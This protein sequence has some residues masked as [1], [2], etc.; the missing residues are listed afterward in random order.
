MD[1]SLKETLGESANALEAAASL[2]DNPIFR[3]FW[4]A[5]IF[6][7]GME[8]M[9]KALMIGNPLLPVAIAPEELNTFLSGVVA[10]TVVCW[11][12]QE[13]KEPQ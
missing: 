2:V 9:L 8:N 1:V 5:P 10:L 12:D 13:L 7:S 3:D 6:Q 4:E 11:E